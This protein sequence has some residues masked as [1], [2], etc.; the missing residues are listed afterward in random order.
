MDL[1]EQKEFKPCYPALSY[2]HG[3]REVRF[4][5]G[6]MKPV[7]PHLLYDSVVSSYLL[8]DADFIKEPASY[9]DKVA[10]LMEQTGASRK[11][12][13]QALKDCDNDMVKALLIL[14]VNV[15]PQT[16]KKRRGRMLPQ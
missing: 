4:S 16:S 6:V 2:K 8:E 3:L 10:K 5:E 14:P 12:V 1:I 13:V 15:E 11:Q 9:E 7:E